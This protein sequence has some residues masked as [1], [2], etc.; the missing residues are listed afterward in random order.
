[1]NDMKVAKYNMDRIPIHLFGS[2][3]NIL[4]VGKKYHSGRISSGVANGVE[5]SM[6]CR[7]SITVRQITSDNR[8]RSNDR[9]DV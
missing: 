1:M 8:P 3:R 2:A 4:N 6:I 9:K 5:D 7:G